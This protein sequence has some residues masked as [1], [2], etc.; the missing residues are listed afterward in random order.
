ML[1]LTLRLGS[2]SLFSA[3]RGATDTADAAKRGGLTQVSRTQSSAPRQPVTT[4][5]Q[6]G[7]TLP[8]LEQVPKHFL[9]IYLRLLLLC[10]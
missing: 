6:P 9:G 2:V 10:S 5:A 3:A 7:A 4:S 1:I 8:S